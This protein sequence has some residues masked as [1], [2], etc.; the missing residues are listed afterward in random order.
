[1]HIS[2]KQTNESCV[3]YIFKIGGYGIIK[4]KIYNI[5]NFQQTDYGIALIKPITGRCELNVISSTLS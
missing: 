1:M 3:N 4:K 2:Y 5:S